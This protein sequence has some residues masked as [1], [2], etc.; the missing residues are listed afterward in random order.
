MSRGYAVQMGLQS[1]RA[2]RFSIDRLV[3]MVQDCRRDEVLIE[4]ARQTGPRFADMVGH[5]SAVDGDRVATHNNKALFL[6]G[7]DIWFRAHFSNSDDSR[8]TT[9]N[10]REIIVAAM[11]PW[12][13]AMELDDPSQYN[14][15]LT[16]PPAYIGDPA[17]STALMLGACSCLEIQPLAL[18]FG[19][20]GS[21]EE[22]SRVWGRIQAG[23]RWYDSDVNDPALKL[24]DQPK[25]DRY[26][27]VEVPL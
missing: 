20:E 3:K 11:T 1:S 9:R 15:P 13:R 7:I 6:E 17:E 10:P 24:G 27:E 23:G 18:R 21:S 5:F 4:F 16:P 25:F 14:G 8:G 2:G 26:E 12:Y 19:F 22:P